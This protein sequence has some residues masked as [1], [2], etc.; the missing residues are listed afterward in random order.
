MAGTA[1]WQAIVDSNLEQLNGL[2]KE[3]RNELE[4]L[5]KEKYTIKL[6]I[7]ED[8][9][10]SAI[11][12]L[13]KMLSNLGQG[14]GDF[15]EFQ[16]LSKQLNEITSNVSVLGKA[17]N[18]IDDSGISRLVESIENINDSLNTLSNRVTSIFGD[19]KY[20]NIVATFNSIES[21]LQ[22]LKSTISDVGD[23]DEFSPLLK[24]ID[25][26]R[27]AVSEL[28]S[29]ISKIKLNVNMDLGSASNDKIDTKIAETN[30]RRL[31][32]YRKLFA[33]MKSTGKT[34]KEMLQFFEPDN[35]SV[36]ELVGMYQDVIQRA[37]KQF[38]TTRIKN[39][40]KVKSN[41]YKDLLGDDYKHEVELVRDAFNRATRQTT[42]TDMISELF[43]KT[44]LTEVI[45]QLE[46]IVK[47]L[48]E[49]SVSASGLKTAFDDGLNVTAS[50]DEIEKLTN[51]VKEL[52]EE[53]SRL[54][55]HSTS[56]DDIPQ[57]DKINQA[58]TSAKELDKTLEQV[59]I[60]SESFDEVLSKLDR[61][62]SELG[63]IVKITKQSVADAE[64]KFSESYTLKDKYGS[65]ETYG[66]SSNT[67]KGQL[68]RSN[69][70]EYDAKIVEEYSKLELEAQ[71]Q[72]TKE[73]QQQNALQ[74]KK[75]QAFIKEQQ[76][77][78]SNKQE[79]EA[80]ERN[81]AAY[82]E[83]I[84]TIQQYSEVMKRVSSGKALP[85]DMELISKFESKISELKK[86]QILSDSQ[87]EESER[88]LRN[89]Y[90]TLDVLEKKRKES[91]ISS[92]ESTLEQFEKQQ[93]SFSIKPDDG[94]S[95]AKWT[96]KINELGGAVGEY[97]NLLTSLKDKDIISNDDITQVTELEK[98]IKNLILTMQKTP[99][100]E[101]GYDNLSARKVAEQINSLLKE[102]SAMS[103]QAKAEIKAYYNEVA[104]GTATRPLKE[105]YNDAL[106][107]VEAE[108]EM[109]RSGKS[110]FDAFKNKVWYGAAGQLAGMFG[111][112]DVINMAKEGLTVINEFDDGLTTI[113]YTMDLT[114]SQLDG[115]GESV[116]G[117][118]K[119]LGT[120]IDNA[121]Q[122]SQIYANLNTSAEEIKKLSE[123]TLILSNLTKFDAS[124]VADDIQAVTQQFDIAA[125]NSMHIADVYDYISKNI[126]VDYAKGIEG[127]ADGLKV[128]GSTAQ[129]AVLNFEQTASI[130]AKAMETTR[131][132]G[133]QVGNGLKTI[134]TRLS[135]VGELSGEVDNDT[136]SKASESLHKIG[137]EV[138]N[139]DGKFRQFDVIIGE[140]ADKWDTLSDAEQA[141]I[142]FNIAA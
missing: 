123:P 92:M 1:K 43:S 66:V 12:N 104:S 76:D 48:D 74:Q 86:N 102:N 44:D 110:F 7:D 34:N 99:M 112:Y 70:V 95:F 83:L 53:L 85:G 87:I 16:N 29:S 64:G 24:M 45:A 121:M 79:A 67:E 51:R 28:S 36:N 111:I 63:E 17:F 137:V 65:T 81:K 21:S 93:V 125:E 106:K 108:R 37:E 50:L 25:N 136:L 2:A 119:D 90:N 15:K 103:K 126:A 131:L 41:I 11:K 19:I 130:I 78:I 72:I 127:M 23:G 115:L 40:Q 94:H 114:K 100:S 138:Y 128:A 32:A 3:F 10:N 68:L 22:S 120:S 57:D 91:Q 73:I 9:L 132:E 58:A 105:I 88:K 142:S 80:I 31:E 96:N 47:K 26:V 38:A 117:M 4:K 118:A 101:R 122:V 133:S 13:D 33:S 18:G 62:K 77:Y 109:G 107:V 84:D 141:N 35:K 59:D 135:K 46:S 97:R 6:N 134:L 69:I 124:T 60:P 49:I 39:G 8:K 113:S 116:V 89:L 54:K 30:N 27:S 98:R 14:T 52:E 42:N 61:T 82:Q 5:K 129:E 139:T 140:L 56:M 20:E 55:L 71:R 75:G